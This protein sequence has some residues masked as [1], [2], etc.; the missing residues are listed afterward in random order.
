MEKVF[1]EGR[2]GICLNGVGN[3]S[4]LLWH[5]YI[6][7]LAKTEDALVFY[8][9]TNKSNEEIDFIKK[10]IPDVEVK[11][12]KD[13]H[14]SNLSISHF[15]YA[16]TPDN[17]VL[18]DGID[19][20][21][22]TSSL[23]GGLNKKLFQKQIQKA[24]HLKIDSLITDIFPEEISIDNQLNSELLFLPPSFPSYLINEPRKTNEEILLILD[25]TNKTNYSYSFPNI[26]FKSLKDVKG[27]KIVDLEK[28]PTKEWI[29]EC[30]PGDNCQKIG[31]STNLPQLQH[32]LA[33]FASKN[34]IEFLYLGSD[35]TASHLRYFTSGKEN[36]LKSLQKKCSFNKK[37]IR[38]N[39]KSILTINPQSQAKDQSYKNPTL[40]SIITRENTVPTGEIKQNNPENNF[41]PI[42]NPLNYLFR[43]LPEREILISNY[44][45]LSKKSSN[46]TLNSFE[47][48]HLKAYIETTIIHCKSFQNDPHDM[49]AFCSEQV[50]LKL[51]KLD[52][53]LLVEITLTLLADNS[54]DVGFIRFAAYF[55]DILFR[56][57][58]PRE[59]KVFAR[60]LFVNS[61]LHKVIKFNSY[62]TL[63][64][65]DSLLLEFKNLWD[66]RTIGLGGNFV[67]SALHENFELNEKELSLFEN[68][69][70]E[71]I[72]LNLD[73]FLT[74][75]SLAMI[76]ILSGKSKGTCNTLS[77]SS[78]F[79]FRYK[80]RPIYKFEMAYFCIFKDDNDEAL[81]FAS[82]DNENSIHNDY[83]FLANYSI[84]ILTD[85]TNGQ[86]P[87]VEL[88]RGKNLW[89]TDNVF[90][91]AFAHYIIFSYHNHSKG[92]EKSLKII[93]N[94]N[95]N[96]YFL[97]KLI[98]K[99]QKRSGTHKLISVNDLE[100]LYQGLDIQN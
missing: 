62:L 65:K 30:I 10:N 57:N 9:F 72:N 6:F 59:E 32:L 85:T 22:K 92:V 37:S 40:K 43:D 75:K 5:N 98:S 47:T 41:S 11:D 88:E 80:Y 53:K 39:V 51:I 24:N 66:E 18:A 29:R 4:N 83:F 36:L 81:K 14:K 100:Y 42:S 26:L 20:N 8:H 49:F 25:H 77:A 73:D 54:K 23:F 91:C 71:E 70:K 2:I 28:T 13:L 27:I 17:L 87:I 60:N 16:D 19:E 97:T 61:S 74:H 95:S 56:Y 33:D 7:D 93:A 46:Q 55:R 76:N 94:L 45:S 38:D 99:I 31:L 78:K 89:M 3:F 15:F 82:I 67:Q 90:Y 1:D 96:L 86:K 79:K 63:V 12:L 48:S 35:L 58:I 21:T 69:C 84:Q 34:G 50:I 52:F 68:I 64:S 44:H